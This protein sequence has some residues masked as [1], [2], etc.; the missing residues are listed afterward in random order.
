VSFLQNVN[1]LDEAVVEG[2]EARVEV[3]NA[4]GRTRILVRKVEGN[5]S[6]EFAVLSG[7]A[8]AVSVCRKVKRMGR[9]GS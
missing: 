7:K 3:L 5:V 4:E 6:I 9:K 2:V 1:T 8:P